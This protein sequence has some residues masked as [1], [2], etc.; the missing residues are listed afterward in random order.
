MGIA[1]EEKKNLLLKIIGTSKT[2]VQNKSFYLNLQN[3]D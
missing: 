2:S 3:Y 1:K